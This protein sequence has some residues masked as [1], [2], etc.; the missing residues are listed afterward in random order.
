MS[1]RYVEYEFIDGDGDTF[2]AFIDNNYPVVPQIE[3]L[4]GVYEATLAKPIGP[5][6]VEGTEGGT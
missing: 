2:H 4:K 3:Y 6:I 5:M 1:D